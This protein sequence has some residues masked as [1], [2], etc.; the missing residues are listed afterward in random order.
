[1]T[2]LLPRARDVVRTLNLKIHDIV[3]QTVSMEFRSHKS[4]KFHWNIFCVI[5]YF[6]IVHVPHDYEMIVRRS[7][8]YPYSTNHILDLWR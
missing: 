5:D 4:R 3:W 7:I 6:E 1:M 8:I 2:E